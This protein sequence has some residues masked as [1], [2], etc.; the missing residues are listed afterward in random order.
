M[1]P[2]SNATVMPKLD[3][4]VTCKAKNP[5][6]PKNVCLSVCYRNRWKS[7]VPREV[8]SQWFHNQFVPEVNKFMKISNLPNKALLLLDNAPGHT[9]EQELSPSDK[10]I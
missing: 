10:K 8:L 5:G 2:C 7:F 6:A 3:L 9:N 1:M 4:L